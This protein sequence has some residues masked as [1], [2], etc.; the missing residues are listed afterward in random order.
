MT[1]PSRRS[2]TRRSTR[3]TRSGTSPATGSTRT[4]RRSSTS[5]TATRSTTPTASTASLGFTPEGSQPN[6]AGVSG[7][8]FQD[9][10]AD[11]EAE[12][13]RHLLFALDLAESAADPGNPVSHMGNTTADF[14][15]DTFK[16]SWGDPQTVQATVKR[17]L[18]AVVMRYRVNGGAIQTVPTSDWL[19]GERYGKDPGVYYHR[20]RGVVTGTAPGDDVQVWFASAAGPERSAAFTYRAAKESGK[21]VLIMADENYTGPTP[22]QDPTDPKYLSYYTAALDANNIAYDVYDVDKQDT[23]SPGLAGRAQ[24]LQGGHLVHRRRLRHPPA[25]TAGRDRHRALQ[26]RRGD[27]RARLHERGRQALL[28]RP[29][30][31]TAVGRGLRGP[32]L[33]VPRATRGRRM[34]LG[35]QAGVRQERP[36][37]RRRVHRPQQRLPP[38]LPGGVRLRA[39]RAVDRPGLGRAVRH[40]RLRPACR[41]GLEVRR[42]R[43]RQPGELRDLP[44]H[45]HDP[46]PG[47][48]SRRSP[49]RAASAAG[50]GRAP[51]RSIRS[52]ARSTRPRARTTRRTSGSTR[53][54]TSPARP[55]AS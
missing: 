19:G 22:D 20:V 24:P 6:I 9:V 12:F 53:P 10:E 43:R 17:S 51:R 21:P 18:G 44:G 33:R 31:R 41:A 4:C 2:P 28:H 50:C 7:F 52:R 14:Y 39:G 47:P 32:Q 54:S 16:Q 13:R 3:T 38:V 30:R 37:A 49:A 42:H 8:E 46:G 26:P 29:E 34:V 25:R 27:R 1:T 45:E 48:A 40:G 23:T 35:R 55:Q 36:V 5:R 15:V 11:I